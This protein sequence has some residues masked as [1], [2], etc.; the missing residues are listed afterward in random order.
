MLYIS[1]IFMFSDMPEK[2]DLCVMELFD[3]ELIGEGLFPSMRHAHKHLLKVI[4]FKL[5]CTCTNSLN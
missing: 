2:A 1:L 4:V 3:T 5:L